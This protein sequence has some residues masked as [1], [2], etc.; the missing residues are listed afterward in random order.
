M[1]LTRSIHLRYSV[2][3]GQCPPYESVLTAL[4]P[5]QGASSPMPNTR[6]IFGLSKNVFVAGLVSL[7]MDISSEMIYPVLPLF[8]ANV[9]GLNKSVIGLIEGTAEATASIVKVFSGYLSD[10]LGN[11]K[12]LMF[13]GYGI[14]TLSRPVL[15]LA[16]GWHHV[17]GYRLM[18]RF[19]KG[20]RTSPRD[21]IIAE[22]TEATHLGRAFGFHRAMDTVGAA[23]GPLIAFGVIALFS[24]G[25]RPV[26]WLSIIPGIVAVLLIV[27]FIKEKT[28]DRPKTEHAARVDRPRLTLKHFDWRFK[29]FVAIAAIFALG[30]SSDAFLILRAEQLGVPIVLI[31]IVYLIFN[32]VDVA[33]AATAG[34]AA[35]RFGKKRLILSGFALFAVLYYGFA[36]AT[37]AGHV[38]VLFAC[39][40][41]FMGLTEGIQKA[42]LSTIIPADFKA[43]GFGVYH[44]VIGLATLPA[45]LI[46]G[47]LWDSVSPGAVFYFGAATAAVSAVLFFLYMLAIRMDGNRAR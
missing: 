38:W 14:S 7:F 21:A 41:V 19:G 29:V 32:L 5:A 34:V 9:L 16:G 35:D 2:F 33:A 8:M 3:G 13:A 4:T 17:F 20:V 28:K 44:T 40:G 23:I 11:R 12:W 47:W 22:S 26:F 1:N 43:T 10:R 37:T 15:A 25:Y 18:D 30:N 46:A 42:Y 39:Y 6:K 45:S 27:F 24:D 36:V 31:P